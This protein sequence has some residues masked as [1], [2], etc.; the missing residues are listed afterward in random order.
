MNTFRAD[1]VTLPQ[2][3]QAPLTFRDSKQAFDDAIRDGRLST[4]RDSE[5]YAAQFMYM[6]TRDGVDTFKNIHTRAYLPDWK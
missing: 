2:I 5:V 1:P 3:H 4:D 6:G